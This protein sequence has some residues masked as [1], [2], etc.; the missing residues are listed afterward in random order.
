MSDKKASR[1]LKVSRKR[2]RERKRDQ[3]RDQAR[4]LKQY[5]STIDPRIWRVRA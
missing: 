5:Q 3:A 1:R 4:E 2:A